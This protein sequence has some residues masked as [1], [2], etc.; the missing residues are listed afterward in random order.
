MN[1][2]LITGNGWL[3]LLLYFAVLFA[4]VKPLGSF[5]AKVYES[6][7]HFL[8]KLLSPLEKAFCCISGIQPEKEMRWQ[9]YANAA[10]MFSF[11]GFLLPFAMLVAQG[12]RKK[13]YI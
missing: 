3:Q 5:I 9:D 13:Q 8:S 10:L 2:D 1:L 6:E 4:C 11:G 12:I 7:R